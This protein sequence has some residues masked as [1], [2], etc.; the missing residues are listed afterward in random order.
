MKK[1]LMIIV[2]LVV[3]LTSCAYKADRVFYIESQGLEVL[4]I[5]NE[6]AFIITDGERIGY[7]YSSAAFRCDL[8]RETIQIWFQN[9]ERKDD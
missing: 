4:N 8:E 2:I 7:A 9:W 1:I 6:Y 3:L 5:I